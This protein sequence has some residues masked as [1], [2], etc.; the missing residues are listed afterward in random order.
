MTKSTRK[1]FNNLAGYVASLRSGINRGWV[2]IYKAAEAGLDTEPG[3][4]AISCETHNLL[5]YAASLP[6]ARLQMKA[7]ENFCSDCRE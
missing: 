6:D 2:V 1:P 4:Y 5:G 3:K 7:P